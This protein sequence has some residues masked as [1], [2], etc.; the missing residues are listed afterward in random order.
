[1]NLNQMVE[2]QI[3]PT[4]YKHYES[5]GYKIERHID[6]N[7]IERVKVQTIKVKAKDLSPSSHALVDV[8][9]EF[10]GKLIKKEYRQAIKNKNFCDSKCKGSFMTESS[11][12]DIETS[13][14]RDLKDYLT[15]EYVIKRRTLRQIAKELYGNEKSHSSVNNWMRYFN[16]PFRYGSEAIE[17]Q[18]INNPERRAK[19][20]ERLRKTLNLSHI[21]K[22]N[23]AIKDLRKTSEYSEW[24]LSVFF[25]DNFTCVKCKAKRSNNIKLVA[26][27]KNSFTSCEELR[28]EVSNGA[29]LCED[30]HYEFH[31]K[32]GVVD[33]TEQQFIEFIRGA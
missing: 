22:C 17:A 9:C 7:N 24:R 20:G 31:S 18:W 26:H 27:H 4:N 19:A 8:E 6:K 13:I 1:M 11:L 21:P 10:C 28:Y 14:G 3:R 23:K 33:N 29:T 5:K 15:E 25:R 12:K 16:I 30:C 32:Y 2:I